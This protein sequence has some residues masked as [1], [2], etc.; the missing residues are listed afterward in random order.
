M[1]VM[2]N[3]KMNT[4]ELNKTLGNLSS[5]EGLQWV[6]LNFQNSAKF[7][8]AFGMEDQVVTHLIAKNK[9]PVEIF[10]LDTGR[11]FQE[12]Y[13]V[14]NLTRSRYNLE[15]TSY[16]PN[17]IKLQ[18]MVTAKGP[19]SFYESVDNRKECCFLRKIEPLKRALANTK[20]WITGIRSDQSN[21][22][23][24]MKVVEWDEQFQL[25]KYNPILNWTLSDVE[26]FIEANNIPVNTLHAK[27]Y[28]SIG[29][30]PC[31]RA[32]LQGEPV[33]AGRWWWENSSKECGLHETKEKQR[34]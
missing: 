33:R 32:T 28:S 29:C 19:N 12:T 17:Q 26:T 22:R 34:V 5:F 31:T 25:L 8:T 13:D 15:I 18:N 23:K 7:S 2:Y 9:L 10:T 6:S 14:M 3:C 4:I 21:N 20:I 30:A 11:L 16:H 1:D 24:D 27:G